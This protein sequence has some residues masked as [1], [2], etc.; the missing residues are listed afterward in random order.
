MNINMNYEDGVKEF[1]K[2]WFSPKEEMSYRAASVWLQSCE[3]KDII[4]QFTSQEMIKGE[5]RY[6]IITKNKQTMD[7]DEIIQLDESDELKVTVNVPENLSI[8]VYDYETDKEIIRLIISRKNNNILNNFK[9]INLICFDKES[10]TIK[11]PNISQFKSTNFDEVKDKSIIIY[12][13]DN[14][15]DYKLENK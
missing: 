3:F 14:N 11:R 6:K 5:S 9:G 2:H 8:L 4:K 15:Y 10:E 12:K 7:I 1:R 13:K